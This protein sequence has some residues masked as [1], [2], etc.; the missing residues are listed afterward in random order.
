MR[1]VKDVE[2]LVVEAATAGRRDAGLAA[3][4]RHPLVDSEDLAGKL[5]DGYE[6]AFPELGRLWRGGP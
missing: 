3:F 1:R 6:T 4:A 2:R 5:L